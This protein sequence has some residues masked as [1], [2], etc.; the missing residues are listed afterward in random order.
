MADCFV[1]LSQEARCVW[2]GCL[3]LVGVQRVDVFVFPKS[4]AVFGVWGVWGPTDV[5]VVTEV[6]TLLKNVR[7]VRLF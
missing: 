5:G 4:P 6:Q 2:G 3:P 1:C 7:C